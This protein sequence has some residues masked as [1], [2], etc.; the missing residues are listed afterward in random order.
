MVRTGMVIAG[1]S[2]WF[3]T[4]ACSDLGPAAPDRE[5]VISLVLMA[6]ESVQVASVTYSFN[7]DDSIPLH[8]P[9]VPFS[10][11]ALSVIGADSVPHTFGPLPGRPGYFQVTMS[12]APGATYRLHGTVAGRPVS[13]QTTAPVDFTILVPTAD[14]VIV[15]PA[16]SGLDTAAYWFDGAGVAGFEASVL[17]QDIH[18][19]P[20]PILSDSGKLFFARVVPIET[21]AP[22]LIAAYNQDASNW[23]QRTPA[24]MNVDGV[25]GGF[26]AAVLLRRTLWYQ[27]PC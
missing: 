27:C 17:H 15:V 11:V 1:L 3:V 10:D 12:V 2:C 23:L 9:P 22:L 24:I 14:T 4:L 26:G 16:S 21:F 25:L 13:A 8:S 18:V 6:G 20:N 19:G 5:P 7:P